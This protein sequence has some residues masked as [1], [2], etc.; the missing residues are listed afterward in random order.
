MDIY[1]F[2]FNQITHTK[3]RTPLKV[4]KILWRVHE[5][6][7]FDAVDTVESVVYTWKEQPK[8]VFERLV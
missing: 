3:K 7:N 6:Q 4:R 2:S 5:V 8:P 1:P